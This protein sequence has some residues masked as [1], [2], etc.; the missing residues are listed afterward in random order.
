MLVVIDIDKEHYQEMTVRRELT[1]VTDHPDPD[2]PVTLTTPNMEFK[3][4]RVV[5]RI[6]DGMLPHLLHGDVVKRL[7]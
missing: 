1:H 2:D 6:E 3:V 5:G 4:T 7:L